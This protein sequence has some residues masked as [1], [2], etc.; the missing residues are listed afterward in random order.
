MKAN[1][2]AK[3]IIGN[4][5]S[6][7][8]KDF[9]EKCL[10]SDYN[11]KTDEIKTS[12]TTLNN[13]LLKPYQEYL[14]KIDNALVSIAGTLNQSLIVHALRNS[15]LSTL[16]NPLTLEVFAKPVRDRKVIFR[17]IIQAPVKAGVKFFISKQKIMQL[18]SV[19]LGGL[20]I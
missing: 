18:G 19:Y 13:T 6:S 3:E 10:G 12:F 5:T 17:S 11:Y 8:L 14:T 15:G 4:L 1:L 16:Q 20:R 7:F 2:I 9:S